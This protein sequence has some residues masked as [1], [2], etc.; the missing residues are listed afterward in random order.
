MQKFLLLLAILVACANAGSIG[1]FDTPRTGSKWPPYPNA[2]K[3]YWQVQAE[4]F[5]QEKSSVVKKAAPSSPIS[6][7]DLKEGVV[8]VVVKKS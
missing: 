3:G 5:E 7:K 4:K 2:D 8:Q 6:V 1:Y